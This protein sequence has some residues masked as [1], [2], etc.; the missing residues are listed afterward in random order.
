MS[1]GTLA[2]QKTRLAGFDLGSRMNTIAKLTGIK[3]SPDTDF[4]NI[5]ASVHSAPDGMKVDNISVIAPAIGELSGGGSITPANALDFKMRAKLHTGAMLDI[6]NPSGNTSI[7]FFI[8]GTSSQPKFV[9]DVKGL[10]S[11]IAA[12]K[13]APFT[14]TDIGKEATGIMDM[15]KKKKP[16]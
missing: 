8:Q 6:V 11:G 7:P 4:D 15:F 13:L 16:N 9:P 5:S 1:D 14:K 12:Q 3:I 2:L 10:V